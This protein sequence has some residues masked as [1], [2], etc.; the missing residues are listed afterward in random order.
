[1][2]QSKKHDTDFEVTWQDIYDYVREHPAGV[3]RSTDMAAMVN[4]FIRRYR[5]QQGTRTDD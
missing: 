3:A 5:E 2:Q 4:Y 1:M